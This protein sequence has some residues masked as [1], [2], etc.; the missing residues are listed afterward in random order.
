MSDDQIK[1]KIAQVQAMYGQELMQKAN[2]TGVGIGYKR[3]KG[4]S[5]DQLAL[6]VMVKEKVPIDD[7]APQDRI[8][9]EIDGIPVDVQDVGGMFFAQ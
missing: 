2:V 9:S 7:L 5:T 3:I 8:P 1:Q 4:E 6:V